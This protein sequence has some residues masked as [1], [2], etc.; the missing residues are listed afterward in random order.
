M[1]D[2]LTGR[3]AVADALWGAL[4]ALPKPVAPADVLVCSQTVL[5]GAAV[6]QFADWFGTHSDYLLW[7][8][9]G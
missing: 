5:T 8:L 2:A 9:N 6:A 3:A 1:A 4:N 7:R